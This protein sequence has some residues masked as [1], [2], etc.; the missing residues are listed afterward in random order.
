[1]HLPDLIPIPLSVIQTAKQ[2]IYDPNIHMAIWIGMH[3]RYHTI[4]IANENRP[5][6]NRTAREQVGETE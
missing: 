1:M 5:L 3:G 2:I 4:P 6:L